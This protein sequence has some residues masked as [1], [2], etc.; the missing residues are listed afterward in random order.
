MK[1]YFETE[2][3]ETE[4]GK[5]PKDWEVR[6]IG[7]VAFFQRGFDLPKTE[8]KS[9]SIPVAG[10]NGIIGYHD[11]QTTNKNGIT[12]GRSGNIGK[13]F[14]YDEDFW[15]HNTVLFV[16]N[17]YSNHEKFIF[18]IFKKLSLK[19]LNSGSA[20]P[21]LNRNYVHGIKIPLPPT[22]SEQKA[23]AKVLSDLD[24]K[25]ACNKKQN[26]LLEEIGKTIF[27][28]WFV[29][30]EFPYEK[31]AQCTDI[32][33]RRDA[34]YC[35]STTKTNNGYKSSGG[36]MVYN[37]ELEKEIPQGWTVGKLGDLVLTKFI[38]V[39]IEKFNNEKIYLATADVENTEIKNIKTKI[40]FTDRPSRANMKPTK[41]SVWFARMKDSRKLLFFD[42][43][44]SRL[45]KFIL[46]TGFCGIECLNNSLYYVWLFMQNLEFE[47]LKNNLASG[48][49]QVAIN[50]E[51]IKRINL[52]TP[53]SNILEKFNNF[54]K[55]LFNQILQNQQ[56]TEKLKSIRDYLLP[57]LMKGEIRVK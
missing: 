6:E 27:K 38:K 46:S 18:Y 49:V 50:N 55:P 31:T 12:I 43:C 40:N 10:S 47:N 33:D 11:K 22:L 9:G 23:I 57:K 51:S 29:D 20:V 54:V 53:P 48:A 21:T 35:V 4:I 2:F 42:D 36:K 8:M 41:N 1:T 44:K 56:Q 19:N 52:L 45:D 17:F 16:K 34:I 28:R 13:V 30:F 14:F 37:A 5:I 3:K 32:A 15:A 26:E 7:E 39:G 24:D 25:I